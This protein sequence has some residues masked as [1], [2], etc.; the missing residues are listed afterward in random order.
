VRPLFFGLLAVY[1]GSKENLMTNFRSGDLRYL[2]SQLNN[3]NDI[4]TQFKTLGEIIDL[5]VETLDPP[6]PADYEIIEAIQETFK[7]ERGVN[8][9]HFLQSDNYGT[10]YYCV[11]SEQFAALDIRFKNLEIATEYDVDR[12]I[13]DHKPIEFPKLGQTYYSID[14][15]KHDWLALKLSGV[16]K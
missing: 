7:K 16:E 15:L 9:L 2:K 14:D 3:S 8:G 6:I 5:L 1:N 11:T 4:G 13:E 10:K 12:M